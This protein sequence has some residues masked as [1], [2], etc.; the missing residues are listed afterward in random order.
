MRTLRRHPSGQM[1]GR[2]HLPTVTTARMTQV[3]NIYVCLLRRRALTT[4]APTTRPRYHWSLHRLRAG[5]PSFRFGQ[6]WCLRDASVCTSL[7]RSYSGPA[8]PA[9]APNATLTGPIIAASAVGRTLPIPSKQRTSPASN[10]RSPCPA[11]SRRVG[12][13]DLSTPRSL[14]LRSTGTPPSRDL[15]PTPWRVR[16]ALAWASVRIGAIHTRMRDLYTVSRHLDRPRKPSMPETIYKAGE[17]VSLAARVLKNLAVKG[18]TVSFTALK[19][20]ASTSDSTYDR[21]PF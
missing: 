20:T 10:T 21:R 13:G 3:T 4:A 18:S 17:T 12:T 16:T 7:I 8:P 5:S 6:D 1:A 11:A 15:A 2:S 19:P 9:P 14:S